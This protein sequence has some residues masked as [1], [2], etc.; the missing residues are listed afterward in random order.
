MNDRKLLLYSNIGMLSIVVMLV[1]ASSK[2]AG[3]YGTAIMGVIGF[4]AA[5]AGIWAAYK[6]TRKGGEK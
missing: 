5:T 2:P 6:L 1:L 4:M 3:T